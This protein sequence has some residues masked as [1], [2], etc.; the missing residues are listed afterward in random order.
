VF[1]GIR[2]SSIDSSTW[3]DLGVEGVSC[4]SP[5]PSGRV[6]HLDGL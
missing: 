4:V 1:D 6:L 5:S 3:N 2:T